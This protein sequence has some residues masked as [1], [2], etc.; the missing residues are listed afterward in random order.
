[1]CIRDRSLP[2][3]PANPFKA[4]RSQQWTMYVAAFMAFVVLLMLGLYVV[5][6]GAQDPPSR[7]VLTRS[8]THAPT[9]HPTHAHTSSPTEAPPE[10]AE[11]RASREKPP[12]GEGIPPS[13]AELQTLSQQK[14][15]E[16]PVRDD[17]APDE[18]M[19]DGEGVKEVEGGEDLIAE[20]EHKGVNSLVDQSDE[21]GLD[22]VGDDHNP[23][24]NPKPDP[25]PGPNGLEEVG[26][27]ALDEL[28]QSDEALTVVDTSMDQVPT[29]RAGAESAKPARSE[30]LG[31]Q[32]L[33]KPAV[34]K[35]K[36]VML[37]QAKLAQQA[38][39]SSEAAAVQARKHAQELW[40]AA[41]ELRDDG[42]QS[43]DQEEELATLTAADHR[44]ISDLAS[45]EAAALAEADSV[46]S[47]EELASE[48]L[49]SEL[50]VFGSDVKMMASPDLTAVGPSPRQGRLARTLEDHNPNP[51][52]NPNLED[53]SESI[54]VLNEA[55]F[56]G[57]GPPS[58]DGYNC[59]QSAPHPTQ[60]VF[61]LAADFVLPRELVLSR[62]KSSNSNQTAV[63]RFNSQCAAAFGNA[64]N[65]LCLHL[66]HYDPAA[67]VLAAVEIRLSLNNN[68][69]H[70]LTL[71]SNDASYALQII[72][73]TFPTS[74]QKEDLAIT[75]QAWSSEDA[76]LENLYG[77]LFA[78]H[79]CSS[80]VF[81]WGCQGAMKQWC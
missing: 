17:A 43:E 60:P 2:G 57:A 71:L 36:K 75:S 40:K 46:D 80:V 73:T 35:T 47:I 5:G 67:Q 55:S 59:S 18:L 8:P 10:P 13:V 51:D 68:S 53:P 20:T 79:V 63:F 27:E 29:T 78:I 49:E 50:P 64:S 31:R 74:Q 19:E 21:A 45:E 32:K 70:S 81:L 61:I 44:E 14:S 34:S 9:F 77:T 42:G 69:H 7:P 1:M 16:T 56:Q 58:L 24:P 41:N 28:E 11:I 66:R 12:N 65:T 4:A 26:E 22:D 3:A 37:R 76:V 33:E 38:A 62:F 54:D 15:G 30:P 25:S 23:P 48:M 52:A 39:E 72:K 6:G